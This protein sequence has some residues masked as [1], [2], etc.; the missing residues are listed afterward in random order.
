MLYVI[1]FLYKDCNLVYKPPSDKMCEDIVLNITVKPY[2]PQPK[3][4]L[5]SSTKTRNVKSECTDKYKKEK[6]SACINILKTINSTSSDCSDKYIKII[7]NLP[8]VHCDQKT[9]NKPRSL[10]SSC[11]DKYIENQVYGNTDCSKEVVMT[12]KKCSNSQDYYIREK[13]ALPKPVKEKVPITIIPHPQHEEKEGC[14]KVSIKV[15]K[16]ISENCEDIIRVAL[17]CKEETPPTVISDSYNCQDIVVIKNQ[18]VDCFNLNKLMVDCNDCI[19]DYHKRLKSSSEKN[20]MSQSDNKCNSCIKVYKN[21]TKLNCE[22]IEKTVPVSLPTDCQDIVVRSFNYS[23]LQIKKESNETACNQTSNETACNQTSRKLTKS[24][25]ERCEDIIL[26]YYAA[27]P[28]DKNIQPIQ[29]KKSLQN[30]KDE[31]INEDSNLLCEDGE[32]DKR[33]RKQHLG[34]SKCYDEYNSTD[35]ANISCSLVTAKVPFKTCESGCIDIIQKNVPLEIPKVDYSHLKKIEENS[36]CINKLP[37]KKS[38][39]RI[40]EKCN[41][42]IKSIFVKTTCNKTL[43]RTVS[44]KYI[45]NCKD[46]FICEETNILC[47]DGESINKLKPNHIFTNCF[48]Q[49]NSSKSKCS[50]IKVK[51]ST[52]TVEITCLDILKKNV[53]IERPEIQI[54]NIP[55]IEPNC[56]K[57]ITVVKPVKKVSEKCADIIISNGNTKTCITPNVKTKININLKICKDQ[58]INEENNSLSN[59]GEVLNQTSSQNLPSNCE[60]MYNSSKIANCDLP[61]KMKKNTECCDDI[62]CIDIIQ[63]NVTASFPII[64]TIIQSNITNITNATEIIDDSGCIKSSVVIKVINGISYKCEDIVLY[65]NPALK[66]EESNQTIRR[67]NKIISSNCLYVIQTNVSVGKIFVGKDIQITAS[68]KAYN[69]KKDSDFGLKRIVKKIS[70]GD[71][72]TF[73]NKQITPGENERKISEIDDIRSKPINIQKY[74]KRKNLSLYNTNEKRRE[75]NHRRINIMKDMTVL[76]RNNINTNRIKNE[77]VNYNSDKSKINNKCF[78]LQRKK[79]DGPKEACD[80][81]VTSVDEMKKSINK[82]DINEDDHCTDTRNK[83]YRNGPGSN[84][85]EKIKTK[86]LLGNTK[87]TDCYVRNI[88]KL[89]TSSIR[90]N[91][92]DLI[93]NN[94]NKEIFSKKDYE[95]C[96]NLSMNLKNGPLESCGDEI[97]QLKTKKKINNRLNH[98][99]TKGYLSM[100]YNKRNNIQNSLEERSRLAKRYVNRFKALNKKLESSKIPKQESEY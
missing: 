24:V 32:T 70:N 68:I 47:Q 93:N 65:N 4:C 36:T 15:P 66:Y 94:E 91:C 52:K 76:T 38:G 10:K 48:D 44:K 55:I 12:L 69:N 27:T 54:V 29:R 53:P 25:C 31:Y 40:S 11:H 16:K 26:Y 20:Q 57:T 85:V 72:K 28:C 77:N 98:V 82:N 50:M 14:N 46:E 84:C 5:D 23:V 88:D 78:I 74:S 3:P 81:I 87:K 89:L 42:I 60:D 30:C 92:M 21:R 39:K 51:P 22:E 8:V 73:E 58:Y 86:I 17:E 34:G 2:F 97:V 99:V 100:I 64:S 37:I 79:I 80:D 61:V 1:I 71:V 75:F 45:Q 19:A 95:P 83:P 33:I 67:S 63:T 49:Y 18:K 9:E 35:L 7:D 41:D 96:D 90:E 43:T 62:N 13:Y 56:N 59:D 6:K